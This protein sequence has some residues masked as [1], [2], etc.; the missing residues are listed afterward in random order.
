MHKGF[1]QIESMKTKTKVYQRFLFALIKAWG[2]SGTVLASISC[3]HAITNLRS[4]L[5]LNSFRAIEIFYQIYK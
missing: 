1:H 2:K 5:V 3:N 4:Y